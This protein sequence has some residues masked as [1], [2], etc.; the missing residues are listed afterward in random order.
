MPDPGPIED[1][2]AQGASV[3]GQIAGGDASVADVGLD[4]PVIENG[5][6]GHGIADFGTVDLDV[7]LLHAAI[8]DEEHDGGQAGALI[9]VGLQIFVKLVAQRVGRWEDEVG[10]HPRGPPAYFGWQ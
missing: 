5:V 4:R 1:Q 3:G 6:A 9:G 2:L 8:G 10:A 7:I